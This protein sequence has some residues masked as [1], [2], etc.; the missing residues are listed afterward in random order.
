M[1]AAIALAQAYSPS[2]RDIAPVDMKSSCAAEAAVDVNRGAAFLMALAPLD[3]RRAFDRAAERDPDCALAGWG[4]AMSWVPID[5]W[6]MSARS[7]ARRPRRRPPRRRPRHAART[8]LREER[9]RAVRRCA[10]GP[11]VATPR[12]GR[13]FHAGQGASPSRRCPLRPA[14]VST[15]IATR[16]AIWR[17]SFVDDQ[18]AT[19]LFA[20]ATLL[21]STVPGD[22]Y[23]RE[24][25]TIIERRFG[26]EFTSG[27]AGRRRRPRCQQRAESAGTSRVR[28]TACSSA[29]R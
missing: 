21:L 7:A 5:P 28:V 18:V 4:R 16:R 12:G 17:R 3:A 23:A 22:D 8:G 14:C 26:V 25:A 24:A 1:A 10:A 19:I 20:R 9:R 27:C 6:R 29:R 11:G 15:A 2:P 13:R